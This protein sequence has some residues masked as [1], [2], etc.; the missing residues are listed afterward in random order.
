MKAIHLSKYILFYST[1][2][3]KNQL[4]AEKS[5]LG[6]YN[7]LNKFSRYDK[8]FKFYSFYMQC[9]SQIII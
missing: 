3:E 5:N 2:F 7:I 6:K 9:F 8:C 1:E 4:I